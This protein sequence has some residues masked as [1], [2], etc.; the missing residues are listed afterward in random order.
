MDATLRAQRR[1]GGGVMASVAD[2]AMMM[3]AGAAPLF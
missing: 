1:D 3:F 2:V